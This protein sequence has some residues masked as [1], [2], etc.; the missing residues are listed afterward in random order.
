M[1]SQNMINNVKSI[2]FT[3]VFAFLNL[4][5]VGYLSKK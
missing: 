4:K 3:L 2:Q 5:S 1:G